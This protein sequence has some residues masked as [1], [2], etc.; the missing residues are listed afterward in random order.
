MFNFHVVSELLEISGCICTKWTNFTVHVLQFKVIPDA[1][2]FQRYI[3]FWTNNIILIINS[4]N[5]T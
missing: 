3:T 5:I 2:H 1:A 4:M